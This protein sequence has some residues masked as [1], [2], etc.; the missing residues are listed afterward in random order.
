MTMTQSDL[1]Q[2]IQL[3][4]IIKTLD[5]EMQMLV[6]S[7]SSNQHDLNLQVKLFV[8]QTEVT[9]ANALRNQI[10]NKYKI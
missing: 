8:K 6:V 10:L 3:N 1:E 5:D 2:V 9:C 4:S 7:F